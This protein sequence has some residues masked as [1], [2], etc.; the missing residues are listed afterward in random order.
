MSEDGTTTPE[1]GPGDQTTTTTAKPTPPPNGDGKQTSGPDLSAWA[2][3]AS[4]FGDPA[5]LRKQLEHARTWEQRAKENKAAATENQ[6]L[7]EQLT[8][9]QQDLATQ[10]ERDEA[11]TEKVALA[12][13][14][15]ALAKHHVEWVD[16]DEVLRPDPKKLVK[17][18]E[19]NDEAI[20]AYAAALAKAH[21]RPTADPDQGRTGGDAPGDMNTLFRRAVQ[22]RR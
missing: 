19:P 22:A 13:L 9:L 3:L 18:G 1:T 8:K 20:A 14:E 12:K 15:A 10:A 11:R 4:E 6:T 16:V 21:G 7:Q 2:D 5:K 17:D